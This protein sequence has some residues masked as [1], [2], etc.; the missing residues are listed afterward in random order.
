M[1]PA[2]LATVQ[3]R[4]EVPGE[5]VD[6]E[7]EAVSA[8]LGSLVSDSDIKRSNDVMVSQG[9]TIHEIPYPV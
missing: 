7:S 6:G 9:K 5:I 3:Q 1:C 8:K 4:D 2:F